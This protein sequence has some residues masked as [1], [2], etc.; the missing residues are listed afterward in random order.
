MN[1]P[2][3]NP[4][5]P[6]PAQ[7]INGA[8]DAQEPFHSSANA[9]IILRSSDSVDFYALKALLSFASPIFDSMMSLSQGDAAK[10]NDVRNGLHI[11]PLPEDNKTVYDLL[12][13]IYPFVER[14]IADIDTYLKV[15][16]AAKKYG[17]DKVE[18]RLRKELV[19]S[20]VME[21]EPFQAFAIAMH[22]GWKEEART[23]AVKTL[24]APLKDQVRHMGLKMISG[25][26]YY[27]LL[28]WRSK[29]HHAVADFLKSAAQ[30]DRRESNFVLSK[31]FLAG[32]LLDRLKATNC[33]HSTTIMDDSTV[34]SALENVGGYEEIAGMW[35]NTISIS[36][37]NIDRAQEAMFIVCKSMGT[38]IDKIVSE[39]PFDTND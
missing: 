11:V 14:P 25:A 31:K 15:V 26:D 22:F 20:K 9:D 30:T 24:P 36:S 8:S 33:P 7:P 10:E 39:V 5:Q 34:V 17:M 32:V 12:L 16:G 21:R 19:T 3:S 29:C 28:Q 23:A 27:N 37:S 4:E 38:Q 13:L 2:P 1:D 6:S 18:D 35:H